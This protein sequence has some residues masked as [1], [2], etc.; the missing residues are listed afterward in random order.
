MG[1]LSKDWL[2]DVLMKDVSVVK[3]INEINDDATYAWLGKDAPPPELTVPSFPDLLK[4]NK[5][6]FDYHS[7]ALESPEVAILAEALRKVFT[8]SSQ[9]CTSGD[10]GTR[11]CVYRHVYAFGG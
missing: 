1:D 5:T 7:N 10:I 8:P 6:L 4:W 2:S 11:M 9:F 3:H